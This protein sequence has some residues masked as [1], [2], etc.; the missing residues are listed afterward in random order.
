[1]TN[2][3]V[4]LLTTSYGVNRDTNIVSMGKQNYIVIFNNAKTVAVI[5]LIVISVTGIS[6]LTVV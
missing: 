3:K 5:K 6:P 4:K 1:M 2:R